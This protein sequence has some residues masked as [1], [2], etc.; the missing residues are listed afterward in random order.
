MFGR[1]AR[2][3]DLFPLPVLGIPGWWPDNEVA[4]FY[5]REDIFR[6]PHPPNP[7]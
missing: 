7:D 4:T 3:A 1:I 2:P 5:G 6:P